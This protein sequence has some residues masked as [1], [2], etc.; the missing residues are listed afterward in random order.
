MKIGSSVLSLKFVSKYAGPSALGLAGDCNLGL[1]PRL[2]WDGPLALRQQ[3]KPWKKRKPWNLCSELRTRDSRT[4]IL[5]VAAVALAGAA[6]A[7]KTPLQTTL[8][9]LDASSAK[10]VSATAKFDKDT[11]TYAVKDDEMTTGIEYAIHKGGS[12]EVG[13]KIIG[14]G[15][16]TVVFKNGEAKVYN[17]VANCFDAYSVAK[18]KGTIDS[19]LALS[20]GASGKELAANWDITDNGPDNIDGVRVEKLDLVPRDQGLKNNIAHVELW[21]DTT[22]A[23]SLKQILY[24]PN[25]DKQTATYSD[26]KLNGKVDASPYE[27]RGKP[28]SK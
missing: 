24:F 10:F 25:R 1:R 28:C 16:R 11:F 8:D 6:R 7:Q 2:G 13:I 14:N 17:P 27:I 22:R 4:G 23:V 9:A 3:R 18:S 12:S 19:V 20:F 5:L 15:A 21:V 26:I